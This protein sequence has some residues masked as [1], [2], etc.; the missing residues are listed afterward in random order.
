MEKEIVDGKLGEK[1]SYK[2]EFKGGQLHAE[3]LADVGPLN[4]GVKISLSADEVLDAI[5]KQIPGQIDDAVINLI[6]QALKA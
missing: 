5:A 4:A 3:L 6:K 1:A 2:V